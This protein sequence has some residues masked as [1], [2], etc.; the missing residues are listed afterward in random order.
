M[1]RKP[2][3][4]SGFSLFWAIY[5]LMAS[6][7]IKYI[8]KL[9]ESELTNVN[10]QSSASSNIDINAM[11][12]KEISKPVFDFLDGEEKEEKD[13]LNYHNRIKSIERDPNKKRVTDSE[14]AAHKKSIE[15]ITKLRMDLKA[16]Q[17]ELKK[18]QLAQQL[19]M[20]SQMDTMQNPENTDSNFNSIRQQVGAIVREQFN[21]MPDIQKYDALPI[22]TRASVHPI[23]EAMPPAAPA[24]MPTPA[25]APTTPQQP[26][27]KV[28]KVNFDNH[29]P[30]PFQVEFT[31]R[32]FLI[33]STRLSFEVIETALSKNFTITLDNG[34]GL[35]LDAIKMQKILKYKNHV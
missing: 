11:I 20:K 6:S 24:P 26:R 21:N 27:A 29:T 3:H 12:D 31:E 33:G 16:K 35:V 13:N 30:Q 2:L 10:P 4:K 23:E 14:I 28:L 34:N 22:I 19:K 18:Q 17:E 25:P 8:D 7:I 9:I 15:K 32:G 1:N 5:M